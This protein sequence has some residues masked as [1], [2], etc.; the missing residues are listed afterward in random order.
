MSVV[1]VQ[2]LAHVNRPH[3]FSLPGFWGLRVSMEVHVLV[4][5]VKGVPRRWL[6]LRFVRLI[7]RIGRV[8]IIRGVV[9]LP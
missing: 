8:V 3:S 7:E 5:L 4:V 6:G 2:V 1:S 9:V